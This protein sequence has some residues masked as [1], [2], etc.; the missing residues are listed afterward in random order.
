[1]RYLEYSFDLS[2]DVITLDEDLKLS[3]QQNVKPWG[4]LPVSWKEGD[5]FK[6]VTD[7]NGTV[8]LL[9][10]RLSN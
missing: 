1:M 8:S 6:I 2:D 7:S 9:R 10:T 4:N 5:T 3:G